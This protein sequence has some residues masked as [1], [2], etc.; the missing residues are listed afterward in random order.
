M[1]TSLYHRG[2]NSNLMSEACKNCRDPLQATES[3]AGPGNE[4]M[5][6]THDLEPK[7]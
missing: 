6:K 5:A 7:G 3:W 1:S 2:D 4:A